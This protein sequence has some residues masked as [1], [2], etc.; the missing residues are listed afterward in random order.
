MTTK[1]QKQLQHLSQR[2]HGLPVTETSIV[3]TAPEMPP[4]LPTLDFESCGRP[5][6]LIGV[7]GKNP[8][9]PSDDFWQHHL[10]MYYDLLMGIPIPQTCPDPP[11]TP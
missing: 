8:C 10:T 1:H 11:A 4:I 5:Y 7:P 2:L 3:V 9:D 6:S